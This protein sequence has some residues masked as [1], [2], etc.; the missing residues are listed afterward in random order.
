MLQK[1]ARVNGRTF[2]EATFD[3]VVENLYAESYEEIGHSPSGADCADFETTQSRSIVSATTSTSTTIH[4]YEQP[5]IHDSSLP[6]TTA[7]TKSTS[8]NTTASPTTTSLSPTSVPPTA[9]KVAANGDHKSKTAP[10]DDSRSWQGYSNDYM[11]GESQSQVQ[12]ECQGEVEGQ[13]RNFR[14]ET[15]L[16]LMRHKPLAVRAT[17]VF[18]NWSVGRQLL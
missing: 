12:G 15:L 7:T 16:V 14:D 6:I 1:V 13:V 9:V 18:G 5:A 2:P 17:I 8:T 3:K 11:Q 10:S 4:V